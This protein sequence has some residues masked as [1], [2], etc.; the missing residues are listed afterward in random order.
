[1]EQTIP[2][3][4]QEWYTQVIKWQEVYHNKEYAG[5]GNKDSHTYYTIEHEAVVLFEKNSGQ[6]KVIKHN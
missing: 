2:E 5:L 3:N 4:K 6:T 1:M